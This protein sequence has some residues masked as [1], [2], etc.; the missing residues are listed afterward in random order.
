MGRGVAGEIQVLPALADDLVA[1]RGGDAV[2][3]EP[4]DRQVVAVADLSGHG[5][6]DRRDLVAQRPRLLRE[7]V[8]R[9]VRRRVSEQEALA[10]G[11]HEWCVVSGAW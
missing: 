11:S 7:H 3:T 9:A 10:G 4:A 1:H 2:A 6:A 5:V 8:A